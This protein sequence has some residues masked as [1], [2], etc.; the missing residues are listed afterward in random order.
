MFKV[1]ASINRSIF[2]T[3]LIVG[4]SSALPKGALVVRDLLMAKQFGTSD[5]VDS[6][7][8]AQLLPS[9]IVQIIATSFAT[10]LIPSF[11]KLRE[12][13][14]RSLAIDLS[15]SAC[16]FGALILCGCAMLL[17]ALSPWLLQ[18]IGS[19]FPADKL[20]R[21]QNFF[22]LFAP[23]VVVQGLSVLWTAL[24]NANGRFALV[25]MLPT[26]SALF[27][28]IVLL[29]PIIHA[30]IIAVVLAILVG[31]I[32]ELAMTGLMM[33]RRGLRLLSLR[34]HPSLGKVLKETLPMAA[35]MA[36]ANGTL[37]VDQVFAS[38][39][40]SGSLAILSY[41]N[42]IILFL[43]AIS[44]LPLSVSVLPHFST[45]AAH[46]EWRSL[47]HS[48]IVWTIAI[49][50]TT[51]PIVIFIN[52]FSEQIVRILFERG[53]FVAEDTI[54]VSHVQNLY[55]IQLPFYLL[56]ILCSRMMNALGMNIRL[57]QIATISLILNAIFDWVLLRWIGLPG[58]AL[59][60]SLVYVSSSILLILSLTFKLSRLIAAAPPSNR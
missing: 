26:I 41:G 10:S 17:T 25:S 12:S 37:I 60:T 57:M 58:I 21:S 11:I 2:F 13:G 20:A 28:L 42:K 14:D 19:G 46:R 27:V 9:V 31:A 54:I 50:A 5:D 30:G 35:G 56:G 47:R 40:G 16:G 29:S 4:L 18:L 52:I 53:N 33:R 7:L 8:L 24:L 34:W 22:F 36:L 44:A 59:S 38:L 43:T 1:N 39:A 45:Q 15:A 32:V 49:L 6:I 51:I 55:A 23:L 48:L 3:F